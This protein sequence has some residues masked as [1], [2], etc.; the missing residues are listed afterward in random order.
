MS[1]EQKRLAIFEG[2]AR[3]GE[4]MQGLQAIALR[5]EDFSS[6]VALQMA[7]SRIYEAMVKALEQGPKKRYVAEVRFRDSMGN[8]VI[9][10]VDLGETP[11]PFTRDRVKA[12]I[13][14]EIY[15]DEGEEEQ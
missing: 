8:P 5:P 12:R 7:L 14:I 15:E 1:G 4:V 11:P 2:E 9:V 10:A 3:V 13:V 6:P